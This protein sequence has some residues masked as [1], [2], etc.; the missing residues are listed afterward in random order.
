MTRGLPRPQVH[1]GTAGAQA[2]FKAARTGR[3]IPL[4]PHIPLPEMWLLAL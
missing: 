4:H 3:E 2:P 1:A